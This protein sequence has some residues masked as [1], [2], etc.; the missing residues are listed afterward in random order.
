MDTFVQVLGDLAYARA[1]FLRRPLGH[2]QRFLDNEQMFLALL[3][4]CMRAHNAQEDA[5]AIDAIRA[6]LVTGV[7][8][9]GEGRTR[10]WDDVPVPPSRQQIDQACRILTPPNGETCTICM[11]GMTV[12]SVRNQGAQTILPCNHSFHRGCLDQWW[13]QSARCPVCRNDI[14]QNPRQQNNH[15]HMRYDANPQSSAPVG[16]VQNMPPS[17]NRPERQDRV[18]HP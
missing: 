8:A 18:D 11:S 6:F 4:E 3:Q 16:T 9:G 14:R 2:L 7:A 5:R 1:T 15:V 17:S 10:F 13:R 12:E